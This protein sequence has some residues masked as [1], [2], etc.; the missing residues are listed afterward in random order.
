LTAQSS[1]SSNRK[2]LVV[3][4][5]SCGRCVRV[6]GLLAISHI[7]FSFGTQEACGQATC[8]DLQE[9]SLS[10]IQK[11]TKLVAKAS[12]HSGVTPH[13][14]LYLDLVRD[15]LT[16]SVLNTPSVTAGEG[17]GES[18]R[19]G[20]Y[21]E[22]LRL[23]GADW[24]DECYTMAGGRR[25]QNVRELV[26]KT[27][28]ENVPGDFLEAGTWRG[29][30]SIMARTVQRIMNEDENRRTYVC[31]SFSGLPPSSNKQD[32]DSWSRMHFLEVSQEEV[33][34]NFKKFQALDSNVLFRKGFFS[35][36]LP[37]IRQELMN[38]GRKLAVLRG[39]G[40]MY[41]SYMDILYN[42][43][44]FVPVGGY[45]ICDDCPTIAEAQR[46]IDDFRQHHGITAPIQKVQDSKYGT[47]WRK[48]AGD[49]SIAVDYNWYVNWNATRAFKE[50]PSS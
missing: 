40:D 46:A 47:Y 39:D 36:T 26:E 5:S 2:T 24:C 21:D 17:E 33:E 18:L 38:Q 50:K 49:M 27:I 15:T 8:D 10:L 4:M 7:D 48:E 16:G 28:G 20:P 32:T 22:E 34:Q 11:S 19:R 25:V 1:T 41:E 44:Q 3:S 45:F 31:D 43:Y 23:R 14:S 6:L 37:I 35:E 30:C 12:L 29:G 42:L 13:E 9:N